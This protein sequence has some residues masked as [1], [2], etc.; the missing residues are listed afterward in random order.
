MC[1]NNE[2]NLLGTS[3]IQYLNYSINIIKAVSQLYYHHPSKIL[4]TVSSS[5]Q[6]F[7]YSIIFIQAVTQLQ[8]HPSTISTTVRTIIIQAVSQIHY[9]HPSS[10]STAVMSSPKQSLNYSNITPSI[11][12]MMMMMIIII[13]M[14]KI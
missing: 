10:I 9:H 1:G 6:Y 14:P 13:I 4:D 5:R 12:I 8:Y 2:L 3:P 11:T 7:N